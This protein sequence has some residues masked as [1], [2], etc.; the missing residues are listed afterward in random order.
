MPVTRT[1]ITEC[2]IYHSVFARYP[3]PA[4]N[5]RWR[6]NQPAPNDERKNVGHYCRTPG[7]GRP[8]KRL[9]G[10]CSKCES[11]KRLN[12]DYKQLAV[13]KKALH[14]HLVLAVACRKRTAERSDQWGALD[15]QWDKIVEQAREIVAQWR[16]GVA[17]Y[18]PRVQA[19]QE[20]IKLVEDD[21]QAEDVV[22]VSLAMWSAYLNDTLI[23][24][25]DSFLFQWTRQVRKLGTMALGQRWDNRQQRSR[26][27][28]RAMPPKAVQEMA[29]W[30]KAAF[31]H[32]GVV[33][34]QTERARRERE[35]AEKAKLKGAIRRLF[36]DD[37]ESGS[38]PQGKDAA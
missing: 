32:A 21:V 14:G 10:R 30:L 5:R 20:I 2:L 1:A 23:K 9:S 7:C 17:S 33:F 11:A 3:L 6:T 22:N 16:S 18:R 25:D 15:G 12:G 38:E 13:T 26:R 36:S 27:V 31:G 8:T 24:T 34:A 35:L 4:E 37:G 29:L 28:Y 19:A